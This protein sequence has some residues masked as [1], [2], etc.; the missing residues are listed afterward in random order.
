MGFDWDGTATMRES[1]CVG[2]S[3]NGDNVTD[4]GIES[5]LCGIVWVGMRMQLFNTS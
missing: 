3:R 2:V 5:K 4:V 1:V